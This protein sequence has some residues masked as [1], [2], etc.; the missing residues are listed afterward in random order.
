M[1]Q[2]HQTV[3][4]T[5][6][7]FIQ[8]RVS[9]MSQP[10]KP[11]TCVDLSGNQGFGKTGVSDSRVSAVDMVYLHVC[12]HY[13]FIGPPSLELRGTFWPLEHLCLVL[14]ILHQLADCKVQH[15]IL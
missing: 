15:H 9:Y 2:M 10:L 12:K 11:S 8:Q 7:D 6:S 4:E 14:E 5:N 1:H 3:F 13:T